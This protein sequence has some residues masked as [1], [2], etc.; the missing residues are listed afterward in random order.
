MQITI[1]DKREQKI[2]VPTFNTVWCPAK[3]ERLT[4]SQDRPNGHRVVDIEPTFNPELQDWDIKL[5]VE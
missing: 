3:G 4:L 5:E 2:I 1:Y